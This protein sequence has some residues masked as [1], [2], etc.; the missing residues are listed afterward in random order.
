M[1]L[2]STHRS[3]ALAYAGSLLT[4]ERLGGAPD[5]DQTPAGPCAG[6]ASPAAADAAADAA[7][8]WR[9]RPA[10]VSALVDASYAMVAAPSF[11]GYTI[12]ES[13]DYCIG[14]LPAAA[15]LGAVLGRVPAEQPVWLLDVGAGGGGFL[16]TARR[17]CAAAGRE[18]RLVGISAQGY[19]AAAGPGAVCESA[20]GYAVRVANAERILAAPGFGAERGRYACIVSGDTFRHLQEPSPGR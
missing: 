4:H 7:R 16:R 10:A 6:R 2:T 18:A 8:L 12:L 3:V 5:G 11:R 19:G 14:A 13:E 1:T 20:A 17:L 15:V 9:R